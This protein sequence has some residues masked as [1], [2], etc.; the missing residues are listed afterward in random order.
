MLAFLAV[1]EKVL[2]LLMLAKD[3]FIK[4]ENINEGKTDQ[5]LSDAEQ[6]NN[7][8]EKELEDVK[9]SNDFDANL[10]NDPEFR[11]RM[12]KLLKFPREK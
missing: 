4:Q 11:N 7:Q 2:S 3:F 10:S 8:K 9:K 1:F 5:K 6:A 12:S